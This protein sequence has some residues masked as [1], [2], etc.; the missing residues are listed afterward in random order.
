[1]AKNNNN[2]PENLP[3]HIGFI[4]DG[5]GRWAKKRLMPRKVGHVEGAKTFKKIVRYCRNIGI[6][7]ISFYA[8]STENWKRPNDEVDAIM[9][10]FRQYIDEAREHFLEETRIVFL[11]VK[12]ALADGL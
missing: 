6:K 3:Q 11:G 2:L 7:C 12:S 1:M 8:F 9:N 4:M 10:L 5:N